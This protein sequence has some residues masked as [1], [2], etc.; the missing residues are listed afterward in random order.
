MNPKVWIIL[1]TAVV[2]LFF[3]TVLAQPETAS[4][5]PDTADNLTG[6]V[7]FLFG[8]PQNELP[9]DVSVLRSTCVSRLEA[10][11]RG[12]GHR[13]ADRALMES[14]I[15]K[16]R[17]RGSHLVSPEFLDELDR[18]AGVGQILVA[19]LL[20][21]N[22]R[23][24][25]TARLID[26]ATGR[27]TYVDLLDVDIP[28]PDPDLPSDGIEDW[29]FVLDKACQ[30]IAPVWAPPPRPEEESYLVLP[31][32]GIASDPAITSAATHSLLKTLLGQGLALIDPS[33]AEVTM[34]EA[35]L[36]SHWLVPLGCR[37]LQ[38]R[39]G[40]GIVLV[41]EIVSYDQNNTFTPSSVFDE[42]SSDRRNRVLSLYSMSMRTVDLDT[43]VALRSAQVIHENPPATGWFGTPVRT[44]F[45]QELDI[46]TQN[47]W[48]AFSPEAEDD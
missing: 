39:F 18:E 19:T 12:R 20:L 6:T 38:D 11:L 22:G 30:D 43:G 15:M 47:L 2:H 9:D 33:L 5:P 27:L 26:T 21:E 45:L 34:L 3:G 1:T 28:D 31:T 16:W 37:N 24:L 41:S 36:P 25:L 46:T 17:V 35:G 42:D 44:S 23:F 32:R 48:A 8:R 10:A 14:K 7:L 40:V 4:A 13:T 29:R